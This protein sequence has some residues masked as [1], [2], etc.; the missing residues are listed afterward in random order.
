MIDEF[1]DYKYGEFEYRYVRFETETINTNNYHG[2]AVINYTDVETPYTR[3]ME[4]RHFDNQADEGKTIVTRE[5]P[6]GWDRSK[7]A[8]YPVND[9]K[10]TELYEKYRQEADGIKNVIFGGRLGS[11]KYYDMDQ[12]FAA[13]L[14]ATRKELGFG[15]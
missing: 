12:V 2:N 9:Q 8:Y 5:Y 13:A 3:S 15:D 11:Y 7:E 6:Q 1:F 4:W 10:N 14:D